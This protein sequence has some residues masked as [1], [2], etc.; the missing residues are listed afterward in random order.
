MSRHVFLLSTLV[1]AV[2][3]IGPS[4]TGQQVIGNSDLMTCSPA[5]CVLPPTQVTTGSEVVDTPIV[6]NPLNPKTLLLG[7]TDTNCFGDD[8]GFRVSHDGGSGWSSALCMPSLYFGDYLYEGGGGPI[9]AFDRGGTAY[10]GGSYRDTN[11]QGTGLIATQHSSDGIHWT[12]PVVSLAYPYQ[13]AAWYASWMKVDTFPTSPYVDRIYISAIGLIEPAQR[14]HKVVVSHSLDGGTN[15][16]MAEVAPKQVY[17]ATDDYT[18]LAIGKD[19]TVYVTWMYCYS[20]SICDNQKVHMLFSKSTDGGRTWSTPITI[21]SPTFLYGLP[22]DQNVIVTDIPVI[23]VDNSD[24]PYAG[25]L[26]VVMYNWTGSFMQVEVI[27]SS[28]GGATWSKPV[29]VAPGNTHDQFFPWLSVSDK[30][31]LGVSWLDRRN[32][33]ANIKYQAFAA[34]S[35]DGGKSFQPD[36]QLTNN[37]S[38]PN[39]NGSGNWMGSYTGDTW[40]GWN[41]LVAWMDS[42][43]GVNMQEVVGG[44]RLK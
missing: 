19:G 35:S 33:P 42:S 27:R 29:P 32:D 24:S 38:D 41:F 21:A 9:V 36:I 40:D 25:T 13:G 14:T 8:A 10:I 15:W 16:F 3:F 2:V 37:F 6:A 20:H 17:P 43:N 44:I 26:Y 11:A 18:H 5:P 39:V 31:L 28:D 4:A 23:A 12:D 7:S 22:P 1:L 34:I 30:G